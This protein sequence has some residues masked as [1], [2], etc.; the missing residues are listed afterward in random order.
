MYM[1]GRKTIVFVKILV[2][3]GFLFI[4]LVFPFETVSHCVTMAGLEL[5][6]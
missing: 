2:S 3:A 5:I 1:D 4:H 6:V